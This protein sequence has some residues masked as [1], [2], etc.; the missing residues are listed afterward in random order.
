MVDAFTTAGASSLGTSLVQK[1]YDKRVES[2]N[3]HAVVLR[4]LADKFPQDLTNPGSSVV[5]QKYVDLTE[6]SRELTDETVDPDAIAVPST[7]NIEIAYREFGA[8][9]FK[10]RKLDHTSLTQV[11]PIIVDVLMRDQNVSLDAEV[12]TKLYAGTNV[13]Y[14]GTGNAATADVAAGDKIVS[15]DVRKIVTGLRVR[16][17]SPRR[18]ELFAAYIHP[19]VALDLRQETGAGAWRDSH[20]YAAPDVFWPGEVG[21]YEGA[22][23]VE[24]ARMKVAT[25][26]TTSATVY[27]TLFVGAQALAEATWQEPTTIVQSGVIV[28]KLNRFTTFGWYGALNWGIYRQENLERYESS[29]TL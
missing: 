14:A 18:G 6:G 28:D 12:A 21:T 11:D 23:F 1:A 7:T 15:G 22:F 25:D 19:N 20:M 17:A 16:A 26:G 29:A 27:R 2:A 8:T 10:T 13:T 24:S 3:R 4:G 9:V 5:L